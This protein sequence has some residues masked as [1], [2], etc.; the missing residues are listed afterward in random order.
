ML[1]VGGSTAAVSN[2]PMTPTQA[3]KPRVRVDFPS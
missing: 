3:P 2:V 1:R